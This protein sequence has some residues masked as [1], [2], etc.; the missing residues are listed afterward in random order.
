M[1]GNVL[2]FDPETNTGAISGHDG[3]RYDFVT[4]EWRAPGRPARGQTVDFVARGNRENG[5][6]DV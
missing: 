4:L 2:G 1:K 5:R 6:A 3:Q